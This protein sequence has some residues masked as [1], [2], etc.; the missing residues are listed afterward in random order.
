MVK[1]RQVRTRRQY[2]IFRQRIQTGQRYLCRPLL[3]QVSAPADIPCQVEL[4][5]PHQPLLQCLFLLLD[6]G[7]FFRRMQELYQAFLP[8]VGQP[9]SPE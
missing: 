7:L 4:P 2:N 5:S 6:F 1:V 8:V 3:L 9:A